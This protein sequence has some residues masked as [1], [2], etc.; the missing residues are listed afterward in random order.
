MIA[1][2]VEEQ[3][4]ATQEITRN[5]QQTSD[6]TL[7][8]TRTIADVSSSSSETGAIAEEV[9]SAA[10]MLHQQATRMSQGVEEFLRQVRAS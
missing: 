1:A 7:D 10:D 4:A 8:V 2:G 3:S 6:G 9:L 5:A